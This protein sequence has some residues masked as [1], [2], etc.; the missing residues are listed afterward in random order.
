LNS[1]LICGQFDQG[2]VNKNIDSVIFQNSSEQLNGCWK[3]KYYQLKYSAEKN[4]G[5]EYKRNKNF[6]QQINKERPTTPRINNLIY[7]KPS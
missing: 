5:T 1:V 2:I 3:T 6:S 4:F 7:Q